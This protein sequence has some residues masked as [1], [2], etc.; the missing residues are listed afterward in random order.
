MVCARKMPVT[1]L[2]Q[3]GTAAAASMP[4]DC[5]VLAT[6]TTSAAPIAV[7][8]AGTASERITIM[9]ETVGGVT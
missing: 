3:L 9:A 6:A 1:S 2:D 7:N 8:R 5:I 4:G